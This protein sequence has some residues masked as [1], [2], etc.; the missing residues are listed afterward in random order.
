MVCLWGWIETQSNTV[1][2]KTF[3]P[4]KGVKMYIHKAPMVDNNL[5]FNV[6]NPRHSAIY[7]F[8]LSYLTTIHYILCS[9]VPM[10]TGQPVILSLKFVSET[11][12][13]PRITCFINYYYL[14][15]KKTF[16]LNQK[17]IFSIF[18]S[19]SDDWRSSH[20]NWYLSW[21]FLCNLC[22]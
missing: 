9:T 17:S 19:S 18:E 8:Y 5:E 7:Y 14:T 15:K 21:F 13:R 4:L 2:F 10:T 22:N 6:W 16:H 3:V 1:C 12:L 20:F 11:T